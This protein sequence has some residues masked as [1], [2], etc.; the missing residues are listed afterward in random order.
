MVLDTLLSSALDIFSS[1]SFI[2][3]IIYFY[4]HFQNL[5]LSMQREIG[6]F[7]LLFLLFLEF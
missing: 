2:I 3:L 7:L 4:S 6:I 1:V 5:Q